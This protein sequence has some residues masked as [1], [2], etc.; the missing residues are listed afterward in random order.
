MNLLEE[1]AREMAGHYGD[2]SNWEAWIP[3]ATSLLRIAA[4]QAERE[5]VVKWLREQADAAD[6]D[7]VERAHKHAAQAI[8]ARE[9][10]GG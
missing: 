5:R 9:H 6:N 4:A 1:I 10:L 3:E 8:E 2:E 7:A